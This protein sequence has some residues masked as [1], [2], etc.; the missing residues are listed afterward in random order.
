MKTYVPKKGEIDCIWYVVDANEQILGRLASD[1][2]RVLRG[3]HKAAF[4]PNADLGDFVVV[5]NAS[6]VAFSGR[7][8]SGKTYYRHSGYPG[9]LR[10]E[11]LDAVL[12]KHPER[13]LETAIRGMLPHN[14]LGDEMYR[15]LK[16]YSGSDHPHNAQRPRH[17]SEAFG[18]DRAAA[19]YPHTTMKGK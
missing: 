1:I 10:E 8:A 12:A 16:V 4:T 6:K 3:K 2:A 14:R 19:R 13:V 17:L 7:K 18:A 11:T 9:G 15:K 5:I